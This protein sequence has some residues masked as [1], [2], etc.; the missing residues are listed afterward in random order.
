MTRPVHFIHRHWQ[1]IVIGFTGVIV[2]ATCV[3]A[4]WTALNGAATNRILAGQA[5]TDEAAECRA[6][7]AAADR[8]ASGN[9][10]ITKAEEIDLFAQAALLGDVEPLADQF[11]RAHDRTTAAIAQ[12]D[13]INAIQAHTNANCDPDRHPDGLIPAPPVE[14]V[15]PL[16]EP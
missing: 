15:R 9:L 14:R 11:D 5:E 8:V 16:E 2:T 6:T 12:R 13:D 3:L 1:A 4:I 7:Y 10:D